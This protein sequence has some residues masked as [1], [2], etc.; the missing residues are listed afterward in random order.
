MALNQVL[1]I[2]EKPS[3]IIKDFIMSCNDFKTVSL[4]VHAGSQGHSGDSDSSIVRN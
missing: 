3:L 2:I 1:K 4:A